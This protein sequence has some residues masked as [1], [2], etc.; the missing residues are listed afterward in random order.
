MLFF[1][2]ITQKFSH[3]YWNPEFP[4]RP[5]SEFATPRGRG[6]YV[7]GFL[8]RGK[9]VVSSWNCAKLERHFPD[10]KSA[11]GTVSWVGWWSPSLGCWEPSPLSWPSLSCR[12]HWRLLLVPWC[13]WWL[14]TSYQRLKS[15]EEQEHSGL[16][17]KW[18]CC[19]DGHV[20]VTHTPMSRNTRTLW[21]R[22]FPSIIFLFFISG[23]GKLASWTSILGFVVMMSLDV[24][25]G[26]PHI[27]ADITKALLSFSFKKKKRDQMKCFNLKKKK[28]SCLKFRN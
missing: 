3:W 5:S 16:T 18:R 7:D 19:S 2:F 23:N 25:L 26:W 11:S 9:M 17:K 22:R 21:S 20:L 14:M 13:M 28:I 10:L 6:L 15:G 1:L 8:V 27:S 24:G 12:T 4:R